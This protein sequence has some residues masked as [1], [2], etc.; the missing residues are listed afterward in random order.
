VLLLLLLLLSSVSGDAYDVEVEIIPS[1]FS[2]SNAMT[3]SMVQNTQK[4]SAKCHKN[5][6]SQMR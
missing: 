6:K 1:F 2:S 3:H 4:I 5:H